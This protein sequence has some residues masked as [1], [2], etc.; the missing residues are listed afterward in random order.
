MRV[1]G[2]GVA[3]A[4]A[5]SAILH[6]GLL[7]V[8]D[9]VDATEVVEPLPMPRLTME[10]RPTPTP[11]PI[12]DAIPIQLVVL[13]GPLP[14]ASAPAIPAPP[15]VPAATDPSMR[16]APPHAPT[17]AAAPVATPAPPATGTADLVATT[18]SEPGPTTTEPTTGDGRGYLSMRTAPRSLQPMLDPWRQQLTVAP[19]G[20]SQPMYEPPPPSGE[21]HADGGGTFRTV[22]PDFVGHVAADGSITFEDKP[23]ASIRIMLPNPR[24]IPRMVGRH[25]EQ[26][27]ADPGAARRAGEVN[28]DSDE[29]RIARSIE[30]EA[31]AADNP[32]VVIVPIIAGTFD[33]T[34][35]VM[36]AAGMDPYAAAKL[37][38]LD[39][40][41]AER[42]EMRRRHRLLE[43]GKST[44]S[45]RRHLGRLWSR[46]ELDDAGRRDAL[47]ELWD[48]C[49]D[50]G[51]DTAVLE[52]CKRTRAEVIGFIRARLPA[53]SAAG[54]S[55]DQLR[56]LNRRRASTIPF[57]PYD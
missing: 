53:S 19:P 4:M 52:A 54:Y 25:L 32:E 8:L 27:Y 35:A 2:I 23:S 33:A 3:I 10:R 48:D 28:P 11:S 13:A 55:A 6:A 51:D 50:S 31:P 49:I 21:L 12:D 44:Q 41:R 45:M 43:L 40:T 18:R 16:A 20:P 56:A 9:A 29:A 42:M 24:K 1:R 47:F 15:A 17:A 34:D 14:A 7:G 5:G 36:R 22:K 57:A 26:W 38:W 39:D 46:F 30:Q 37:K